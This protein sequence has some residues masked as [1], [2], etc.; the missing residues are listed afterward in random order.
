MYHPLENCLY[1]IP[2]NKMHFQNSIIQIPL[3]L[4]SKPYY[5]IYQVIQISQSLR[6]IRIIRVPNNTWYLFK[7][8]ISYNFCSIQIC[9]SQ[10]KK[11]VM[12]STNC[13]IHLHLSVE[14][15]YVSRRSET[16]AYKVHPRHMFVSWLFKRLLVCDA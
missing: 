13:L 8:K 2:T 14:I 16:S 12:Q 9:Q 11:L 15:K 7:R 6:S 1:T 5:K 10:L 4:Y 3:I